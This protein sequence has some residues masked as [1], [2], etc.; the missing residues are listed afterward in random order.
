MKEHQVQ[1]S[2]TYHKP[3]GSQPVRYE[4]IR[5]AAK[6]FAEFILANTPTSREQS[7]A[8]TKLE[9]SVMWANK[10]I[11]CNEIEQDGCTEQA[12]A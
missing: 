4:S 12:A 6:G 10:A 7:V 2:F 9:E 11:A 8:I 1:N 5:A 3:F